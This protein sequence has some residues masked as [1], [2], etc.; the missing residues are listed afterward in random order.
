VASR[1]AC[2]QSGVLLYAPNF[3][4]SNVSLYTSKPKKVTRLAAP[5]PKRCA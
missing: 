1:Q 2:A 3:A 4:S 5:R